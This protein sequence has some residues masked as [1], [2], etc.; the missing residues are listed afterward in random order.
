M[1]KAFYFRSEGIHRVLLAINIWPCR[2]RKLFKAPKMADGSG[3]W[4]KGVSMC[5]IALLLLLL[6]AP[7]SSCPPKGLEGLASFHVSSHSPAKRRIVSFVSPINPR[8]Q[9]NQ[10]NAD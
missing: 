2:S 5:R 6:V 9:V 10:I 3:G 4:A 8:M 1:E 7:M